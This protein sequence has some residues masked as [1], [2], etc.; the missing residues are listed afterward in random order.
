MISAAPLY[1]GVHNWTGTER[2]RMCGLN[3][4]RRAPLSDEESSTSGSQHLGSPEFCVGSS[5]SKVELTAVSSSG[6]SSS[7]GFEAEGIVEEKFGPKLE[8]QSRRADCAKKALKGSDAKP[9]EVQEAEPAKPENSSPD[10]MWP[11]AKEAADVPPACPKTLESEQAGKEKT[12]PAVGVILAAS[13]AAPTASS[14]GNTLA[15]V[16]ATIT[17]KSVCFST[18]QASAMQ[19]MALSFPPGAVLT[20]SQPVVYL[21]PLPNTLGVSSTLA[22]PVLPSFQ[23]DACLPGLLTPSELHSFPYAFSVSR[24]VAADPKT[25]SVEASQL[26]CPSSSSGENSTPATPAPALPTNGSDLSPSTP[27][28]VVSSCATAIPLSGATAVLARAS[29]APEQLPSGLLASI[30]PL[31]SPP[32]LEREMV[33]SPECSEMPL[34]LSSKSN[35]QKLPPP[36]QRKTPPMPVLTPI[37]ASSKALLATALPKSQRLAQA[38]GNPGTAS[39]FVIFPEFLRNG[40]QGPWVK[41]S[42]TLISAIPGT[43]VGVANPVPA[44]VLLGKDSGVTFSKDQHHLPKQELISIIDQGEPRNTGPPPPGKKKGGGEGQADPPRQLLPSRGTAGPI[45]RP[46]KELPLWSPSQGNLFSRCSVKGRPATPHLLPVGWSHFQPGPLLSIGISAAGQLPL[47]PVG[48]TKPASASEPATFPAVQPA[49]P[50]QL[51]QKPP[52]APTQGKGC[53]MALPNAASPL[54][55]SPA[56]QTSLADARGPKGVAPNCVSERAEPDSVAE[57]A[58]QTEAPQEGCRHKRTMDTKPK[59]QFLTAYLAHGLPLANQP[60]VRTVSESAPPAESQRKDRRCDLPR[61]QPKTE[62]PPSVLQVDL[63]R[64]KKEPVDPEISFSSGTCP[65]SGAAPRDP[66]EKAKIKGVAHIKVEGGFSCKPNRQHEGPDRQ[67]HKKSKCRVGNESMTSCRSDNQSQ[68]N[69]KWRKH[70]GDLH[71]MSKREGRSGSTKD[72]GSLRAKRKRRK[73]SPGYHCEEGYAEKKAKNNFRDFIPVVL[74]SRTR[75]QS[76]SV[77]GSSGSM[78]GDCDAAGQ[79]I[80]PMLDEEEE[81]EEDSDED[82]DEEE[83]GLS[84]K[85]HRLRKSHRLS[86]HLGC[87]DR[88]RDRSERGTFPLSKSRDALWQEEAARQLWGCKKEEEEEEEEEEAG[89]VK[90]KKRRRQKSWKYQTGEYLIEREKEE[91]T[92]C[93]HKRRKSKA[94][95]RYRKHKGSESRKGSELCLRSKLPQALQNHLDFRNG[96][97]LDHSDSAPIQEVLDK[98]SGKRKCKTKHLS[99]VCEEGKGKARWN[100]SKSRSPKKAQEPSLPSKSRS[101]SSEKHRSMEH[102][103]APPVPPEA[104][105]LIVNK[106]AGETLL[107]RAARLG[108]KDVVM[109]CLQK[110]NNDVNHRDNAGYTALHEACARG[111]IDILHILLEHGANVN[112][113]AQDGTRPVHDA[114]V[115]DN[116][117]TMWLLLS[118]GA[119]PTLATYSGQTALKLA[120][121]EGMKTFLN[122][123]L[124]DLQGRAN[125]D[126]QTAWDFYSSA[127]LEGKD[128]IGCDLLLNPPGSSDQ[129]EDEQDSD[130]FV[131]EFSDK[132]LLPCYNLQVSVSRGP[133]NWFIFSDVLKRLKLSSRIFQARFPHF[134][135]ATLPKAE[136]QHQLSLSQV[137]APEEIQ[138]HMVPPGAAETVELVRYEPELVRLL[139]SEVAFEAWSS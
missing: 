52:E 8:E 54:C 117:E 93:C 24:P 128:E 80:M 18:S 101:H 43:Y 5:F 112:C 126:P 63:S 45:L 11:P 136:F 84:L 85:H 35:R 135:V 47:N 10:C 89:H 76:G 115:N 9:D 40:E 33:A 78:L 107:Q 30:S 95:F 102:T 71:E 64:V 68:H 29:A 122:D 31:K 131:F 130:R 100:Q 91:H 61:S 16:P 83:T 58:P 134:E 98:P 88:Q 13:T 118:Y 60:N 14:S 109:Y 62:A 92:S 86:A 4:E 25:V 79:E 32:Q 99:G 96:F 65:H 39:P 94:D 69:R 132:Q 59:N 81:E 77:G 82:S 19:K 23:Q 66:H 75:S 27:A 48:L 138:E 113:S 17:L 49:E 38:V 127:V 53:K 120:S 103:A 42:T 105:R 55:V 124:L 87:R 111:W 12:S 70:H 6:S 110:E 133:C 73:L 104:R 114:V 67:A 119:D 41:S 129:E 56:L 50:A 137:L 7:Q 2:I 46:A 116:L 97:L 20:P 37:H 28:L 74:S 139:G 26:S 21:P 90:R 57:A 15:T 36:S 72:R 22:L 1:S 108:Y 34:D 106:N 51:V 44:S 3:E 125:D 123:Y 121:S